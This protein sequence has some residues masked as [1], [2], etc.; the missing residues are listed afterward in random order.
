MNNLEDLSPLVLGTV[1]KHRPPGNTE[2]ETCTNYSKLGNVTE[3]S[4]VLSIH[5]S[6]TFT[7]GR[8]LTK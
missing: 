3:Y 2:T 8:C 6:R 1:R 5:L 7:W 4:L